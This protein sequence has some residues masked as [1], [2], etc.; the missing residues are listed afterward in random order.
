MNDSFVND[1]YDK[2]AAD[3]KPRRTIKFF[4]FTD[5]HLDLEYVEGASSKCREVICCRKENG[6]PKNKEEQAPKYGTFG[7]DIP[8]TLIRKMGE[9]VNRVINP[10]VVLWTG[11]S[12]PHDQYNYNEEYVKMYQDAA[13]DFMKSNFTNYSLYPLEGNHDFA[14][15]NSQNFDVP[16]PIIQHN[17]KIWDQWLDD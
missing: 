15:I 17:L 8:M 5:L 11:D 13:T 7:C 2:M 3:N 16:D 14:I 1:L 10:D 12:P 9:Y 4:Q 6:F